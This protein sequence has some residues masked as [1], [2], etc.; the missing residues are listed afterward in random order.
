LELSE[1]K[2]QLKVYLTSSVLKDFRE[3]VARKHGLAMRGLISYEVEIALKQYI[4]S[5][6]STHTST[7]KSLDATPINPFPK[8]YTAKQEILSWLGNIDLYFKNVPQCIPE[9]HLTQAIA[10]TKGSDP[11]TIR[12]WTKDL[13]ECGCIKK[14]GPHQYE[15]V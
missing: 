12:R 14:S 6:H 11:R 5:Y 3:L 7:H 9:K 1:A 4:A 2:N 15:F 13:L 10:A 8:V